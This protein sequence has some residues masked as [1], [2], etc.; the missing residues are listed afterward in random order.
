MVQGLLELPSG[1]YEVEQKLSEN[2]WDQNVN[3][4]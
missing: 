2:D 1:S 4:E 3:V